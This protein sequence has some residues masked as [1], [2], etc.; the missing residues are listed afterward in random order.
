MVAGV[1]IVVGGGYMIGFGGRE[2]ITKVIVLEF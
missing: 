2:G 1:F